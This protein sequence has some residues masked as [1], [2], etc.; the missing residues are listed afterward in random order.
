MRVGIHA[1]PFHIMTFSVE[2]GAVDDTGC[3]WNPVTVMDPGAAPVKSP[4]KDKAILVVVAAAVS[5]PCAF[6]EKVGT[7][8]AEPT[9]PPAVIELV[10]DNVLPLL[11]SPAPLLIS[12]APENCVHACAVV[13]T[14]TA[15]VPVIVQP[16]PMNTVPV[17]INTNVPFWTESVAK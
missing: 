3:V 16:E 15:V 12:P 10:M 1:D 8:V 13:S 7:A 14:V 2:L 5:C 6:Q 17:S 11:L 4:D 9:G